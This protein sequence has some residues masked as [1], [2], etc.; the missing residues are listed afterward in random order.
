MKGR[1]VIDRPK[2]R[3]INV[4]QDNICAKGIRTIELKIS[5]CGGDLFEKV[6]V[7]KKL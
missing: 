7:Y 2:K 6:K 1:R 3:W 4:T 5:N